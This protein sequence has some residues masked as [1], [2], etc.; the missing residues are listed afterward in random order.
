MDDHIINSVAAHI[1]RDGLSW[2][3]DKQGLKI[4][5][6]RLHSH[7]EGADEESAK[8]Y[9]RAALRCLDAKHGWETVDILSP[10]QLA[11]GQT[12]EDKWDKQ[13][14]EDT[15]YNMLVEVYFLQRKLDGLDE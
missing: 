6:G 9:M 4:I 2:S 5:L 14:R 12:K 3:K 8:A 10:A 15:I 7:T 11:E 13:D 1:A